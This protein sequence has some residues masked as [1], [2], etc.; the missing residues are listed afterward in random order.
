MSE[1]PPQDK[2]SYVNALL[3]KQFHV[4]SWYDGTFERFFKWFDHRSWYPVG[5]PVG[6]TIYPGMQMITVAFYRVLHVARKVLRQQD[7]LV[8]EEVLGNK[9]FVPK[10]GEKPEK[11][12]EFAS[13]DWLGWLTR[14][15]LYRYL[16]LSK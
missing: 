11:F 8:A 4:R 6:T 1:R 12:R 7:S 10:E 15:V 3:G 2:S 13:D 14:G 5:R 9:P 16:F